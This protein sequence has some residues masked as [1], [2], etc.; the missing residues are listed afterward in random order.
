MVGISTSSTDPSPG[1]GIAGYVC[2][3]DNNFPYLCS[4]PR[5]FSVGLGS[6]T[7]RVVAY[8]N[9]GNISGIASYAWTVNQQTGGLPYTMGTNPIAPLYPGAG[10]ASKIDVTFSNTN[11]DTVKVST[12]TVSITTVTG[13]TGVPRSCTAA[14]YALT[15]Y[16]GSSFFIPV[17]SSSLST[18]IPAIPSSTW[19]TIRMLDTGDQSGC[20]TAVVHLHFT[21]NP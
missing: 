17:G 6:H 9:A 4:S 3:V 19:P 16:T 10:I 5:T 12:L 20:R 13:G 15:N 11:S 21:G 18:I 7:F 14:D 1:S 2:N 8:D